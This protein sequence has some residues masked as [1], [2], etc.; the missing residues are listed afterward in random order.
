MAPAS[1]A[2]DGGANSPSTQ[3]LRHSD[4]R[5]W[6]QGISVNCHSCSINAYFKWLGSELRIPKQKIEEWLPGPFEPED[7]SRF[8]SWKPQS[9]TGL[10]TK[11]LM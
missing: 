10:R 3:R 11:L 7:I 6:P 5:G 4:A 9:V 2:L 8:L 1:F